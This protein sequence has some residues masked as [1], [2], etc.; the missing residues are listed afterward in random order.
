MIYVFADGRKLYSSEFLTPDD[1]GKYIAVEE[2][3]PIPEQEGYIG[4]WRANLEVG[5]LE[6]VYYEI[7][8]QPPIEPPT[9]PLV[10]DM[11]FVLADMTIDQNWLIEQQLA[12]EAVTVV[13]TSFFSLSEE[14]P[15]L[16]MQKTYDMYKYQFEKGNFVSENVKTAVKIGR[17]TPA[18]FTDITGEEYIY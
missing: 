18:M 5:E 8:P 3:P 6:L 4:D 7:T 1:A 10:L 11:D 13:N 17:L 2:L 14:Q 16:Q 12:K 15:T 9:E